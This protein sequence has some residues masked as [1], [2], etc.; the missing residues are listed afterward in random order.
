M[1]YALRQ[2]LHPLSSEGRAEIPETYS[3][4]IP[5][6]WALRIEVEWSDIRLWE[7]YHLFADVASSNPCTP[8]SCRLSSFIVMLFWGKD[9]HAT[10]Q[11]TDTG[12]KAHA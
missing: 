8:H 4:A 10:N 11:E 6:G 3:D 5:W 1:H 7:S 9:C 2:V 12:I